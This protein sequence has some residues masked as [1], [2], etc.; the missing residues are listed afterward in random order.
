M[1]K[2]KYLALCDSEACAFKR[3]RRAKMKVVNGKEYPK[4]DMVHTGAK[5]KDV[6]P[7]TLD[8]PDCGSALFWCTESYLN[9][10]R[11]IN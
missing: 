1:D 8:C 2:P 4:Y 11:N 9:D 7:D 10:R 6:P 5:V 3:Q